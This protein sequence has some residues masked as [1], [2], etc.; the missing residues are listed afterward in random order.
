MQTWKWLAAML[1]LAM[2]VA[3]DPAVAG[4]SCRHPTAPHVAQ[5]SASLLGHVVWLNTTDAGHHLQW[6]GTSE[7][8]REGQLYVLSCDGQTIAYTDV[9]SV[10][11]LTAYPDKA[12]D[13]PAVMVVAQTTSGT[14]YLKEDAELM[15]LDNGTI[16]TVWTHAAYVFASGWPWPKMKMFRQY[17]RFSRNRSGTK[18]YVSGAFLRTYPPPTATEKKKLDSWFVPTNGSIAVVTP[19]EVYCWTPKLQKFTKCAKLI[20]AAP[21]IATR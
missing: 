3:T 7:G 11:S 5:T 20:T 10:K 17:F 8:L 4:T 13:G 12:L 1:G 18:I 21:P 16:Q 2:L 9:G 15:R 6:L 19:P 14:G